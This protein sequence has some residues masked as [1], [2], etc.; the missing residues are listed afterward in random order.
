[1]TPKT[2]PTFT[3]RER[4]AISDELAQAAERWLTRKG[5][6]GEVDGSWL[7]LVCEDGDIFT[8]ESVLL[9]LAVPPCE[10]AAGAS[11]DVGRTQTVGQVL[12]GPGAEPGEV[13][14]H[15]ALARTFERRGD[16]WVGACKLPGPVQELFTVEHPDTMLSVMEA[17]RRTLNRGL[18]SIAGDPAGRLTFTVVEG[19]I[20]AWA[21]TE[22]QVPEAF[23]YWMGAG[24]ATELATPLRDATRVV[25]S[26]GAL[27]DLIVIN[28]KD[29]EARCLLDDEHPAPEP[30]PEGH[31]EAH[32]QGQVEGLVIDREGGLGREALATIANLRPGEVTFVV[33]DDGGLLISGEPGGEAF[34][35]DGPGF[36]T[37]QDRRNI[38]IVV[39]YV[40][41]LAVYD[42]ASGGTVELTVDARW[43]RLHR[44]DLG[45]TVEWE[46]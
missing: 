16:A 24:P 34:E 45:I 25:G 6:D 14:K 23:T 19:D 32:A 37:L 44:A 7:E 31:F 5:L 41:A 30:L 43:G 15:L 11:V 8:P 26:L 3:V 18:L 17:T 28:E 9:H 21:S 1:M 13:A 38:P 40:V 35:L 46:R 42:G 33:A 36:A 12:P 27:N 2:T 10:V 29:D 4:R 22:A 20:A 39:P